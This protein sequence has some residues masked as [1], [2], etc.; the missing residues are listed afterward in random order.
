M[1]VHRWSVHSDGTRDEHARGEHIWFGMWFGPKGACEQRLKAYLELTVVKHDVT[2]HHHYRT[3]ASGAATRKGRVR[4]V[5]KFAWQV[6]RGERASEG[7]R[8]SASG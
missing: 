6:F 1:R 8:G 2:R 4:A 7:D 3:A 5:Q